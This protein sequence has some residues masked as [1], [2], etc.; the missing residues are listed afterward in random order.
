MIYTQTARFDTG[1]AMTEDEMR[2]AAPSIFAVEAH[3]SR[4]D[5]FSAIPTIEVLRGLAGEGFFPVAARQSGTRDMSR[6]EFTKHAVRLRRFDNAE[7]YKVD[8][9]V[10]EINLKNAN[11]GTCQYDLAAALFRIACLNSMVTQLSE[12]DAVKIRHSGEAVPKVIEGTYRVLQSA[13][14]AL[15]A[16]AEWSQ[17]RMPREAQL[18]LAEAVHTVR[19]ADAEGKVTTPILPEQL[20]QA[21]RVEDRGSDLWT[22]ANVLQEHVIRGGDTAWGRD[23]NNRR[24]RT[25]TRAV[26]GIEGDMKLNRAIWVLSERMAGMLRSQA[27]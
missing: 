6:K 24:R 21:R 1:R 26:N 25:T 9:T 14:L 3:E 20:L 12:V 8:D 11:D 15:A 19:F 22:V 17:I 2:K 27:A 18:A 4:S 7:K 16:P 23:A 13:Q 5:R 10:F